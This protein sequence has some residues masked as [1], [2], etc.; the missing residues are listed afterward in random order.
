MFSESYMETPMDE[1][2]ISDL[3]RLSVLD[4]SHVPEVRR[5]RTKRYYGVFDKAA[6]QPVLDQFDAGTLTVN[7]RAF[8]DS[9]RRVKDRVFEGKKALKDVVSDTA[10][11]VSA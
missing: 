9:I 6:S 2:K 4:Y 11:I 5:E 8:C 7:V 10:N 1:I 3:Y